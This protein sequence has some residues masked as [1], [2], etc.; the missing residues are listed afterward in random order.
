M[1]SWLQ[2]GDAGLVDLSTAYK[3][4][5]AE[6]DAC[7]ECQEIVEVGGLIPFDEEFEN[8]EMMPP[9]HPSCRCTAVLVPADQADPDVLAA[10]EAARSEREASV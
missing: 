2:A 3:E 7:P 10:Q 9:G 5:I 6:D 4:W 1:I 8:G